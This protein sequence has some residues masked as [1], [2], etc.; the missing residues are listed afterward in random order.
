[1]TYK[2][3]NISAGASFVDVLAERFLTQYADNQTELSKVLIL[4]P[5]RRACQSLTEAF[6]RQH[7]LKPTIL[8][9]IA[10]IMDVEE[11]E[12]FLT[13]NADILNRV[14]PVADNFE[15]AFTLTRLIMQKQKAGL[16]SISLAQAYSLAQNLKSLMDSVKNQ[17][18]TFDKLNDLVA[19]E[20]AD[21]WQQTLDL[22]KIITK[23]WPDILAEK[24]LSDAT[25]YR[26]ELLNAQI[27]L[28]NNTQS[29]Q[30]IVI[31]GTTA[32]Y[33]ILKKLVKTVCELPNGELYLYGLDRCLDDES[34]QL[35]K[36][37]ENHPQFEL[38]ELL[39]SLQ[40]KRQDVEDICITANIGRERLV[41][42]IMRPAKSTANWQHLSEDG[43]PIT[44]FD[45]IHLM[46][47]TDLRQEAKAIAMIM[48]HTLETPEKTAALVT[49]D[50]NLARRVVSEL[51]QWE[52]NADDSAGRPLH[53]TPI[54]TY[55][56]LILEYIENN[57]QVSQ[58]ALMKHPFT[59]CGMEKGKYNLTRDHLELYLRNNEKLTPKTKALNDE[60]L[61]RIQLLTDLYAQPMVDI[62]DIFKAHIKVAESL[63]DTDQKFG[64]QII[65]R[66]DDGHVAADFV[67]D[68]NNRCDIIGTINT[69]E[70]AAFFTELLSGYS[71]RARYGLH[72]RVKILGPIE[73]RLA[74]Y[75]VT[76]IGEANEG[77]WPNLPQA[78]MWM[79]RPMKETFGLP[80]PERAIGVA[81]ADFAHLL[82][83]PEVYVTRAERVDDT[84]TNK[85]RWW[86]RFETVLKAN[87]GAEAKRYDF[88]YDKKYSVWAKELERQ[89][90]YSPISAPRPCPPLDMRPR[91]LWAT[92]VETLMRD[93]YTIF[94]KSILKIFPLDDL[95]REVQPYDYGNIVHEILQTYNN[96]HKHQF[97]ENALEELLKLGEKIF[98]KKHVSP[99]QY[100]FWYPQFVKA[101]E[102]YVAREQQYRP[103][104][105]T[106][107][108]EVEG[109]MVFDDLNFKIRA[110]ADRVDVTKDGHINIID[111][112]TGSYRKEKE[113]V[114]GTAPQLPIEALIAEK[115]GYP[116]ITPKKVESLRYW[117][118][119]E[120]EV[121]T[122]SEQ[123]QEAVSTICKNLRELIIAFDNEARP[124]LAKPVPSNKPIYSDYE[125]L[126]RFLEWSVKD[127][128]ED[129][130]GGSDD[131]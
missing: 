3:Y 102:W 59:K 123:T 45:G 31:A 44:A 48:R 121:S 61:K 82:N 25:D 131:E 1:M 103:E 100:A 120:K 86:L 78:D 27:D 38:K 70:Y 22:L 43:L 130:N 6:L 33:P 90:K 57:T 97:P 28:W 113:I 47:C 5:T 109:S 110:K 79:S 76:I 94:A 105:D 56:R 35:I 15:I 13:G 111:Y 89:G 75:D 129:E 11:D 115:G 69:N 55:L 8:P 114:K 96:D 81:A 116:D 108:N 74:S 67:N 21:H 54:G 12:I 64:S 119:K 122:T 50:R 99:E 83:A 14:K 128:D 20:Y 41:S 9:K 34:W 26:Q 98:D 49:M 77:S 63:A 125:H 40:V 88:L 84:P 73:A 39:D 4:L 7:E 71:V 60:F 107:H 58:I 127:D 66:K 62:K 2:I 112:K 19:E 16:E 106:I 118:F 117:P 92:N 93:P 53:L 85:S 42:Q 68:F 65:W 126:S 29:T 72:P 104:I 17:D 24:G 101:M 95:D 51:Q 37:D 124:Y 87:F 23:Y 36:K 32:A 18:L 10:P 52:I 46:S 91:E 80:A 30:R